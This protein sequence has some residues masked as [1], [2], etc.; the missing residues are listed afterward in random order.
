[1]E[2]GESGKGRMS[3]RKAKSGAKPRQGSRLW[4]RSQYLCIRLDQLDSSAEASATEP[5]VGDPGL[6]EFFVMRRILVRCQIRAAAKGR[7][8]HGSAHVRLQQILERLRE[9]PRG[10]DGIGIRRNEAGAEENDAPSPDA[11]REAFLEYAGWL[12]RRLAR[13]PQK[14]SLF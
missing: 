10:E 14:N 7:A 6:R 11:L 1:M 5:I 4:F 9:E 3:D 2:V 8:F 13:D 12:E